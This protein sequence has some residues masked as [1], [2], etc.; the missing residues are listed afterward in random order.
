[1]NYLDF[2]IGMAMNSGEIAMKCFRKN[3]IVSIKK[4]GDYESIVTETDKEIEKF[5][6]SEIKKTYPNH[7]TLGE[8]YGGA[9]EKE[10]FLWVIDPIDGTENFVKGIDY[11]SVSI[12]LQKD[13][14]SLVGVVYNPATKEL[15]HAKKGAGAYLNSQPIHVSKTTSLKDAVVSFDSITTDEHK[16]KL[17][18]DIQKTFPKIRSIRVMRSASLDCCYI[19]CGRYDGHIATCIKPWDIAAAGL[20]I[21][22]AGGTIT[23]RAGNSGYPYIKHF[24]ASNK[25]LHKELLTI[26]K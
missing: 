10:N 6:T 14:K 5:I 19:A 15:F 26:I 2:A 24:V 9:K 21:E 25:K 8:E 3:A 4:E 20:I 22:E 7:K 11:F 23:D 12:A 17:V 18:L 16:K 1:M 13:G